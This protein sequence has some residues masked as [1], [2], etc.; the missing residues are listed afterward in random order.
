MA[1]E[2]ANAN[3]EAKPPALVCAPCWI[4]LEDGPDD[5]GEPLVRDC[6][7]RGETS[8]G[9]H[10]S[11]I[12]DYAKVKTN[13]AIDLLERKHKVVKNVHEPWKLCPNCKQPYMGIVLLQLAQALLEHTNHLPESHYVRFR[14]RVLY[15]D[16]L[17]FQTAFNRDNHSIEI[18][19]KAVLQTLEE[20][21]SELAGSFLGGTS[22]GDYHIKT[23]VA[24]ESVKPLVALGFLKRNTGDVESA[25]VLFEKALACLD[26]AEAAGYCCDSSV[27]RDFIEGHLRDI[28]RETGLISP[29][30]EVAEL[31]ENLRRLIQNKE[32]GLV[33][34]P[35]KT[36]LAFALQK[37]DPPQY[38]E[39]IKLLK[40]CSVFTSQVFG[41]DHDMSVMSKYI[42]DNTRNEYM[43]YLRE[44]AKKGN[45]Q[46]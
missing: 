23:L 12:I 6:A 22:A 34:V 38:F 37:T 18:Q 5:N 2:A 10:V 21:P 9:Y 41:P 27:Q 40:E 44:I 31:R 11:C 14:A 8:A 13:E 36:Q 7:C 26:V 39:A 45:G 46:T 19:A 4:C 28:K 33:I 3:D 35:A 16:T 25:V 30:E 24:G 15:F 20:N 29:S 17:S 1:S 42:Y 32:A 43:L